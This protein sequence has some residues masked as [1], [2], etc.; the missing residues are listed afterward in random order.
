[1]IASLTSTVF[2]PPD[3]DCR[4]KFRDPS[5]QDGWLLVIDRC[6]IQFDKAL[7]TAQYSSLSSIVKRS[8]LQSGVVPKR[9][10]W[11]VI[12]PV[13][14]IPDFAR[15]LLV[16]FHGRTADLRLRACARQPLA[17]QSCVVSSRHP[18]KNIFVAHTVITDHPAC[19]VL[20]S[21]PHMQCSRG[22]GWGI[23]MV[24]ADIL[25]SRMAI[26]NNLTLPIFDNGFR[27]CLWSEFLSSILRFLIAL[28]FRNIYR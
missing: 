2:Q 21:V 25:F 1:M 18:T 7:R 5:S 14:I 20:V 6:Y 9:R 10:S 3:R 12:V 15:K 26:S 11:F 16:P 17:L 28:K 22:I 27:I 19:N 23:M 4:P 24:K 13:M 8:R